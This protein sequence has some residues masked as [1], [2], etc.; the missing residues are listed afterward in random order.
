MQIGAAFN[1]LQTASSWFVSAYSDLAKWRATVERLTTFRLAIEEAKNNNLSNQLE[2]AP[3]STNQYALKDLS[4]NLPNGKQLL[5]H[6]DFDFK[7]GEHV[8]ITGASGCGKSTLFRTLAG[9]WPFVTGSLIRPENIRDLFL[10]QKPYLTIG[11]L[12]EQLSYPSPAE[13]FSD[14]QMIATLIACGLDKFSE[15]LDES[16]HWAHT[17]SG[18]EQ[19]RIAICR[20]LLQKPDWLFLDESTSAVDEITEANLYYTLQKQL[21]NTTII[22]IGHRTSLEVLHHKTINISTLVK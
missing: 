17:L 10:P 2:I 6:I 8:L 22:S 16:Q 12:R 11:T 1:Q 4:L 15:R 7:V 18:G 3:T 13:A 5:D 21:P 14:Q 19:Q 9:I 20:A